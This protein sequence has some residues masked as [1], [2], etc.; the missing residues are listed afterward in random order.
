VRRRAAIAITLV[1]A[2][3]L[4]LLVATKTVQLG[5]GRAEAAE[6]LWQRHTKRVVKHVRRHGRV[7]RVVR[8]R[9]WWTCE[10]VAPPAS[11]TPPAPAPTPP[12]PEP[13]EEANRLAVKSVEYY[14]VLSRPKVHAGELT[15]EL[16]NQGQDAHNLNLQAESGEGE[17][18]QVPE[19][20]SLDHSVAHFDLAPG[21]YRLWCSLPEHEEK[22][23]HTTL[24]VE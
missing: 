15:V 2:G 5:S 17:V 22:G 13:E 8:Y 3:F 19:T 12:E 6:C 7:R 4:A 23:M 9:H 1:L 16:N 24:V 18:L 21:K 14:F 20:Q 11:A 10:A